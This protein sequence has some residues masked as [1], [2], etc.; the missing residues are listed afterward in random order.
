MDRTDT[1][2]SAESMA[3][4]IKGKYPCTHHNNDASKCISKIYIYLF[5]TAI[6]VTN[7]K[8]S[9]L[10][11]TNGKAKQI[12][13]SKYPPFPQIQLHSQLKPNSYLGLKLTNEIGRKAESVCEKE[14]D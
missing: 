7:T 2:A 8:V 3:P 1:C 6:V 4:K 9:I 5:Y 14:I 11:F 10:N 12:H 13:G